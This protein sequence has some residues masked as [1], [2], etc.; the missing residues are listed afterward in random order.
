MKLS[1]M[2]GLVTLLALCVGWQAGCQSYR[3][4]ESRTIGEFYDDATIQA[5][6]KT[7]LLND[8]DIK[9]LRINTEVY[10]GVVTL[11]GRVANEELRQRAVRLSAGVHGVDKVL[12]RLTV[13]TE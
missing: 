12:D 13:V 3:D 2:I 8:P 5:K 1:R 9:F 11:Y 4:A 7:R 10:R 6:V